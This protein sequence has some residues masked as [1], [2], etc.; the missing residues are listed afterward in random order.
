MNNTPDVERI[1]LDAMLYAAEG[2]NPAKAIED[3]ERRG[4]QDVVRNQRLPRSHYIAVCKEVDARA[5]YERMGIKVIGEYDGLFYNVALPEGWEIRAS[6]YDGPLWS[7]LRDSKGRLRAKFCY[8]AAPYDRYVNIYFKCRYSVYA[9]HCAPETADWE[10]WD[11][12]DYHGVALDGDKVI[13]E[14]EHVPAPPKVN[15][16]IQY[17]ASDAIMKRLRGEVENYMEE[18]FPQY[19]DIN[20]YWD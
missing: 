14:T 7:E 15:G 5:Q 10:T 13:Y 12:S 16:R 8:K 17:D 11:A 18:H 6:E 20:A 9:K 19:K 2:I 1:L 4:Q 3:A